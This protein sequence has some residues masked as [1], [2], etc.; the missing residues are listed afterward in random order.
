LDYFFYV[1]QH[2]LIFLQFYNDYGDIIKATLAKSREINKVSTA[3]T[4]AL[5]LTQVGIKSESL[6]I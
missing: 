1:K 5:S 2:Y 3:K 6:F 4:L